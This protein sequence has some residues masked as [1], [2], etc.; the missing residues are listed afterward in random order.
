VNGS[1]GCFALSNLG[2]VVVSDSKTPLQVKDLR[3][4]MHSFNFRVLCLVTYTFNGEMRFYYVG[5][6]K[7]LSLNQAA[8]LKREFMAVLQHEVIRAD[9]S[10]RE[11][12]HMLAAVAK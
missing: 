6:E 8:A 7:C 5:D 9:D 3:L 10:A 11:F 1:W 2:N 12:S 4:Y